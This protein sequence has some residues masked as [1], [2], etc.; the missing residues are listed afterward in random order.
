MNAEI[1]TRLLGDAAWYQILSIPYIIRVPTK[2]NSVRG[3][4]EMSRMVSP[5]EG[6]SRQQIFIFR[7]YPNWQQM[8][9][10]EGALD[11]QSLMLST[12][13]NSPCKTRSSDIQVVRA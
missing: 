9:R 2:I 5:G 11:M 13:K 6:G 12:V 4:N 7:G 10:P 1:Y 8:S 3:R